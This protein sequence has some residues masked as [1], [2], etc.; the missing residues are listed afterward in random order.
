M[1]TLVYSIH[2]FDR[3][4]LEKEIKHKHEIAYT[5]KALIIEIVEMARGSQMMMHQ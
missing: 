4:Y 3:P 1:K 2:G 5:E